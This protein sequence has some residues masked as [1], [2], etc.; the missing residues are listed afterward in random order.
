MLRKAFFLELYK[1]AA[2]PRSYIGFTAIIVIALLVQV[3]MYIDGS[4][5]LEFLMQPLEQSF[6][7]EGHVLNGNLVALLLLQMLVVHVPLLVALVNGDLISGEA[8]SGTLRLLATKPLSRTKLLMA[9][10]LAGTLYTLLLVL[11]LAL[12]SLVLGHALFGEGDLVVLRSEELIII[13]YDDT[14]WR[15]L[16]AF[17]VA[18]LAMLLVASLSLCLSCFSDN[19]IGPIVTTMAVI[20]L[21]NIIASLEV[22]LFD[23]IRPWLFT[24]HMTSW[25]K[26]F[27]DP[28]Q[29]NEITHSVLYLC[30]YIVAFTGI[31][32]YSFNRKDILS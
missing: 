26:F 8:A 14:G 6:V 29:W 20:L 17:G 23:S 27:D 1:I 7:F 11:L 5:Y 3:A 16:G 30:G 24:T 31:T 15:F 2:R 32:L 21:F 12:L 25:R 22:P 19:S 4:S 18:F 9:K 13:P 28:V 10:F